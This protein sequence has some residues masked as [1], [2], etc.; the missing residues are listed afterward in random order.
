MQDSNEK[1]IAD[2]TTKSEVKTAAETAAKKAAKKSTDTKSNAE[3][4]ATE[5]TDS[6]KIGRWI[7]IF[8]FLLV[9]AGVLWGMS[10]LIDPV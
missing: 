8:A 2:T 6:K 4:K 3:E 5:K 1:R 10:Y 7:E 9:L